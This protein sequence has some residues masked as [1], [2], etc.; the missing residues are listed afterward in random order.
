EPFLVYCDMTADGGGWT[1]LVVAEQDNYDS[2]SIAYTL[3]NLT[4]REAAV[5]TL[6]A[7]TDESGNLSDRAR[8][9]MPENWVS[10]SPMSWEAEDDVVNAWVGDAT[11]PVETN[12]RY[13]YTSFYAGCDDAWEPEEADAGRI[14]LQDT[15]GPFW[16][17]FDRNDG[18]YCST[19]EENW[20]SQ[21]CAEDR[22]FTIMVRRPSCGNGLVEAGETCDDANEDNADGCTTTCQAYADAVDCAD[23]LF[24]APGASSGIYLVDPDGEG[25]EAPYEVLC[26][27][28]RDGG[29]WTLITIQSHDGI[30]TWTWANRHYWDTDETTFGSLH[31][32]WTQDLKSPALHDA[33]MSD[34]LF[35]HAP[36]GVWAAYSGV[37]DGSGT[38]A[39]HMLQYGGDS[40]RWDPE[41]G[42]PLT[43]GTLE[44]GDSDLCD[45]RLYFNARDQDDNEAQNTYGPS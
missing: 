13:G 41:D 22:R 43:A 32:L 34:M 45:D 8:F 24:K 10:K 21:L 14:C 6:M 30:Y 38:V 40:V 31:D 19:S 23:L 36:S 17:T 26:D 5:E 39:E 15:V 11:E 7:Y 25:G 29:G 35:V 3:D 28:E 12:L 9:P 37:S 1:Q 44:V 16:S 20:S 4:L 18:D 27:M 42:Y 2:A 33:P